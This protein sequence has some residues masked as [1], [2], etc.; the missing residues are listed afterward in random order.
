VSGIREKLEDELYLRLA[1]EVEGIKFEPDIFTEA[2]NADPNLDAY[3]ACMD[4]AF[5]DTVG[6]KIPSHFRLKNG[7]GVWLRKHDV[8]PYSL[9]KFD[10]GIHVTKGGEPLAKVYF[11]KTP[12]YYNLKTSDGVSMRLVCQS[13]TLRYGEGVVSVAYSDE[14]SLNEKGNDCLFCNINVTKS[15]FGE[16]EGHKWKNPRQ[17]AET[18]KAAFDEG[19]DHF[20]ITGGFVP[21]RRELEYYIDVAEA[22]Q[23]ETGLGDFNGTAVIGAP[24]DIGVLDK[25]K[26]AGYRTVA[27]HPEVWGESFFNAICPGKADTSGGFHVYMDAIDYALEIFGK[28]RVRTQF[29][30]GLQPK[31]QVIDGLEVLAAKGVVA[32][33]I[34][35]VPNIGSAFEGH[36]T[37]TVEWHWDLQKKNYEIL[38]R[39]GITSKLLYDA[40]PE[41][42]AILD[43]YR[44][45][46]GFYPI[47]P[48]EDTSLKNKVA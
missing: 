2:I 19:F 5:D 28:G 11:D 33:A 13:R 17:I 1:L 48:E 37:P 15:R 30:A 23:D 4:F 42:R 47:Y 18:V 46:E 31:A 44:A 35:W 32:L 16:L 45:D 6:V 21:E 20:N 3:H 39:N 8:S 36:R 43:F 34:P 40:L 10:D 26:D 41:P 29:V 14:C 7:I 12:G 25:Y 22:I 9:L 27:I 24:S 38:K